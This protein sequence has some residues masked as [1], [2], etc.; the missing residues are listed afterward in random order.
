M[1]PDEITLAKEPPLAPVHLSVIPLNMALAHQPSIASWTLQPPLSVTLMH[2]CIQRSNNS[3]VTTVSSTQRFRSKYVT[4]VIYKPRLP[5]AMV[6]AEES[7]GGY[8]QQQQRDD[9]A[10][11]PQS[12]AQGQQPPTPSQGRAV[13]WSDE[14]TS[15][16][17]VQSAQQQVPPPHLMLPPP[18][19]S[20]IMSAPF[21]SSEQPP[22][23]SAGESMDLGS[24]P[25]S[26]AAFMDT[27]ENWQ[28]P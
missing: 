2:M 8:Q 19:P 24:R 5:S 12:S 15:M 20:Q 13:S 27:S 17:D 23:F 25:S 7:Q 11:Q 10:G 14:A 21:S 3:Q 26:Q 22:P 9:W 4:I 6:N 1:L 28:V 16:S 18:T